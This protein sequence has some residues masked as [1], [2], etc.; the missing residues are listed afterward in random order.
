MGDSDKLVPGLVIQ[1]GEA[2]CLQH[3]VGKDVCHE[4]SGVHMLEAENWLL[5]VPL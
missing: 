2:A 4:V 5:K 3:K 1:A